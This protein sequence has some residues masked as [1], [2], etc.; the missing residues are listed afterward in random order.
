MVLGIDFYSWLMGGGCSIAHSPFSFLK[1]SFIS[2]ASEHVFLFVFCQG[3]T[4]GGMS[5]AKVGA[6]LKLTEDGEQ[7]QVP[8][9]LDDTV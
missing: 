4:I 3:K 1:G 5:F 9:E 7:Y 2:M 6:C 8:K